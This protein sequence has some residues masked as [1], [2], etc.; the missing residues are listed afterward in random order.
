MGQTHRDRCLLWTDG[1]AKA[2]G[3]EGAPGSVVQ[4]P[5]LFQPFARFPRRLVMWISPSAS[6]ADGIWVPGPA[7]GSRDGPP[8]HLPQP[9]PPQGHRCPRWM[10]AAGQRKHRARPKKSR[11]AW[12]AQSVKLPTSA[13]VTTSRF[14]G[15]SPASGSVLTARSPEPPSDSVSPSPS[16]SPLLVLCLCLSKMNKH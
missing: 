14:T 4:R 1:A 8:A 2:G 3:L 15:S 7:R 6:A 10:T 11:G 5:V 13:Q 16:A 9:D 12:G